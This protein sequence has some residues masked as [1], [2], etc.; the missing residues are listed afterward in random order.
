MLFCS[1]HIY[2]LKYSSSNVQQNTP[3][4]LFSLSTKY[5]FVGEASAAHC[6]ARY[7]SNAADVSVITTII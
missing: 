4:G 6:I 1:F 5:I 2:V 3:E 7:S